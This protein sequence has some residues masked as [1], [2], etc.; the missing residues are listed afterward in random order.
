MTTAGNVFLPCINPV[1]MSYP[2]TNSTDPGPNNPPIGGLLGDG[3]LTSDDGDATGWEAWNSNISNVGDPGVD[4][5]RYQIDSTAIPAGATLTSYRF[6]M[7]ARTVPATPQ[8]L[9]YPAFGPSWSMAGSG[10]LL[11]HNFP[12][13]GYEFAAGSTRTVT[14][15]L[16][17]QLA[18]GTAYLDMGAEARTSAALSALRCTMA[19]LR[20]YYTLPDPPPATH[21]PPLRQ[22]P[23][24][25]GLAGSARRLHPAPRSRQG[26]NRR[27][28]GYL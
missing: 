1:D 9:P 22:F 21:A 13:S 25:D 3:D 27:A 4:L 12:T 19:G 10:V 14:T 23:R 18:A 11:L 26:S 2:N 20:V 16:R 7:V 6:E 5:F 15:Q 8:G 24:N 28:G 17:D